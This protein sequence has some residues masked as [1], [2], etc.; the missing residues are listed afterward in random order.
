MDFIDHLIYTT[1]TDKVRGNF[2]A[3]LSDYAGSLQGEGIPGRNEDP[4]VFSTPPLPPLTN[5]TD[6]YFTNH[7]NIRENYVFYD[8]PSVIDRAIQKHWFDMNNGPINLFNLFA[9]DSPP[10]YHL[11]FAYLVENTRIT[12]I[13]ERLIYLFQHDES[14]GVASSGDA[15]QQ[16]AFQWFINTENLFFKTLS[17]TSY[18]NIAGNLRPNPE[19]SRRNAYYRMLG[20]DLAFGDPNT[21]GSTD[22]SY[23]KAKTSNREFILLFEQ[24][25]SE[26]WQAYINAQ[27]TSG[28][29]TTDY[30]RIIDMAIKIRQMLMARRGG[31]GN[32]VLKN[33]RFMNLSKEE[34]ASVGFMTWLFFIISYDSPVVNFLGCQANTSSERLMNIGKKVGL[35]AHK[36]SQALFDMAAPSAAILR[37]IEFGTFELSTV[38]IW[39]RVVIESQTTAGR[40]IA[41]DSQKLAL[42]DLLT[43]INNWEKATGHR[44]KN[45]EAT[46]NAAV[47]VQRPMP[48]SNGKTVLPTNGKPAA[49]GVN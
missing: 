44:I 42:I 24:F 43:V 48:P 19:A 2:P 36:R 28:A 27:N 37:E 26:I 32:I 9:S 30:Q 6:T 4:V 15:I 29:N 1:N 45:P 11:I 5:D 49:A 12:Q 8:D 23:F 17:N 39:I 7:N 21:T 35:D 25:L 38:Q 31:S 40:L 18:R 34:Y 47:R 16:Q 10:P 22:Y 14:L 46:I 20:M 3:L 13:F 33:Y 41:S